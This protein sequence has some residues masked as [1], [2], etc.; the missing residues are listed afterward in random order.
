MNLGRAQ[1]SKRRALLLISLLI[2][3]GVDLGVFLIF[4]F[5]FGSEALKI[6]TLILAILCSIIIIRAILLKVSMSYFDMGF[7]DL[8]RGKISIRILFFGLLGILILTFG[9]VLVEGGYTP[10]ILGEFKFFEGIAGNTI[11]A[12]ILLGVQYL[13]YLLEILTVNFIYLSAENLYGSKT[14]IAYVAVVWGFLHVLNFFRAGIVG[15][16]LLG[17]YMILLSLVLY[18]AAWKGKSMKIPIILWF[19][20]LIL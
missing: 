8:W 14:S 20:V 12:V 13:Y 19:T 9:E 18:I 17:V 16:M 15:A 1:K 4:S 2:L 6:F 5:I 10:Q 3:W 7:G 11:G